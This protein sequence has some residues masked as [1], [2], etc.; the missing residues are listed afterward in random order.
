MKQGEKGINIIFVLQ[1]ENGNAYDL[2]TATT[3]QVY[4]K[5]GNTIAVR[6]AEIYSA[7]EGKVRY[8]VQEGDL[9]IGDENYTFQVAVDFQDGIHLV[10]DA[11][12]EYVE[13]TLEASYGGS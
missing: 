1:D 10:S 12:V 4:I 3:V 7:S 5:K 8:T 13:S 6:D 9:D 11:V 2:S